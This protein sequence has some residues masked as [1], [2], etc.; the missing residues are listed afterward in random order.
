MPKR[1][2]TIEEEPKPKLNIS[3][4]WGR[5]SPSD[6]GP[7]GYRATPSDKGPTGDDADDVWSWG[8]VWNQQPEDKNDPWNWGAEHDS[9]MDEPQQPRRVVLVP[10]VQ[11]LRNNWKNRPAIEISTPWSREAPS[12][13]RP[14]GEAEL[15]TTPKKGRA[16]ASSDWRANATL[17][18]GR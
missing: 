2:P 7:T 18:P 5:V 4:P 10:N 17:T 14:T 15:V 12:A 6:K 1:R 16:D 9:A 8:R 13:E 3:E 11:T